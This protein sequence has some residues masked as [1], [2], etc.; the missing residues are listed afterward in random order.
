MQAIWYKLVS[1][2][3]A[4]RQVFL[5]LVIASTR[6]SPGTSLSALIV[7]DKNRQYG[8]VGG[9]C[10][11][12]NLLHIARD[13]LGKNNYKTQL[14]QLMHRKVDRG[15][16]S[17]LLCGGSQTNLLTLV[18]QS[19]LEIAKDVAAF[20]RQDRPG[21]LSISA[22]NWAFEPDRQ[23]SRAIWLD[24]DNEWRVH[25]STLNRK[26]VAIFGG[27][28]CGAAL[29]RQMNRLG[30]SVVLIEPRTDL[31][32]LD[33][34]KQVNLINTDSYAEGAAL[35]K[36]PEMTFSVVLTPSAQLDVDALNGILKYP[37]PFIGV[38]GSRAKIGVINDSLQH[39]GFSDRCLQRVTAP[40][41][42]PVD[43]DTPEEIA[44]SIAAQILS[45]SR[46]LELR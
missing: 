18:H 21:V 14:S 25:I 13:A 41:G 44:V 36:Y 10:M 8:T 27:G 26:R 11:E 35:V 20:F 16:A 32:T 7:T 19:H 24:G 29:A 33:D 5:A 28:H 3:E 23:S 1:E 38:M 39:A 40:V 37:F 4:G 30:F 9:G 46:K 42:L 31:F 6:G 34:I 12:E 15:N 45:E 17:G 43:S 2:L 22:E